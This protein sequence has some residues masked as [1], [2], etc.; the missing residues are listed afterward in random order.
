MD[1][2]MLDWLYNPG[3]GKDPLPRFRWIPCEQKMYQELM[4]K[5]FPGANKITPEIELVFRR[6]SIER[7]WKQIRETAKRT[8]PS[9]LIWLSANNVLSKEYQGNS[10]LK[11]VDWLLNELGNI[12][13][14]EAMHQLAT[15]DTQFLTCLAA[16][17]KQDPRVTVP[18][19]L[20]HNI[21]LFGFTKPVSGSL[22]PPVDYYLSKPLGDFKGDELNIAVLARVYNNLPLE[23]VAEKLPPPRSGRKTPKTHSQR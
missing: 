20:K 6:K 17:N 8:K 5:P 3:G 13:N 10:I 1:G 2:F 18:A 22:M 15:P 12:E 9:C 19:A 7:A 16:W 11:E 23:Y 4:N 14:T 21:G